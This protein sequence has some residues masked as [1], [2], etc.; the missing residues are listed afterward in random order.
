MLV[1]F[2]KTT[3]SS[4]RRARLEEELGQRAANAVRVRAR[5]VYFV[6]FSA[7]LSVREREVLQ[8]LLNAQLASEVQAPI[9]PLVV[10]PRIGTITAWSSKATALVHGAG[11][12]NVRRVEHGRVY[13]FEGGGD[14]VQTHAKPL[15]HNRMT[16]QVLR[17]IDE[18]KALFKRGDARALRRVDVLK[19][20]AQELRDKNAEWGLALADEEIAYL[21]ESFK[22]LGRNPSD[23]ELMMFAQVNS[24]H[25]RVF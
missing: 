12:E 1:L 10:V 7:P 3:L 11:I 5:D 19:G 4:H 6:D 25:C 21:V 23:A 22:T 9:T 20:G 17:Q 8:D 18:A 2:G 16:E 14:D 13:E 15:I 24:E